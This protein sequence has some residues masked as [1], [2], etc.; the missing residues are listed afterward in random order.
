MIETFQSH[1]DTSNSQ[2]LELDNRIEK[3]L[4]LIMRCIEQ[5]A[6]Q[7]TANHS[8]PTSEEL[9]AQVSCTVRSTSSKSSSSN[10]TSDESSGFFSSPE[11]KRQKSAEKRLPSPRNEIIDLTATNLEHQLNHPSPELQRQF[12][13]LDDESEMEIM[14]QS[15]HTQLLIDESSTDRESRYHDQTCETNDLESQEYT[16]DNSQGSVGTS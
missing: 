15:S 4:E 9:D 10:N 16:G 6:V 3:R 13:E 2:M 1:V 7:S 8:H 5:L 14:S 12:A 11:R